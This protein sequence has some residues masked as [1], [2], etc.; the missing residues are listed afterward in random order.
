MQTN[1]KWEISAMIKLRP[2]APLVGISFVLCQSVVAATL[3]GTVQSDEHAVR[4]A[5]VTLSSA[6][7]MVSETVYSD[8]AGRYQLAT[9]LSG[10]LT[11]RARAPLKADDARSIDVPAG[12]AKINQSLVLRRLMTPQAISDSL[13][14]SAHFARIK[15]PTLI[16]RE[17]FQT[18]CLSCHEIGN[19]FTR[20]AH[21]PE[22]WTA[23]LKI[24]TVYCGYTSQV[25]VADYAAAMQHAFD[26]TPT[27][28]HEDVVVDQ[29][30]LGARITEWK[31]R[32]ALVA[33]DTEFNPNDGKFYTTDEASDRIFVTDP[34]SNITTTIPLPD[35]GTPVGG[36]FAERNLPVPFNFNVRHG[37]HSLQLAADGLFYMTGA[38]GG[39]I[40][41]FDPK[42]G[43]YKAYRIGGTALY[44]HTLRF[45]SKG[46]IWF[47]L[48][49]SNQVGRF[50][51]RTGDI[52]IIE[53]PTNMARVD[54]RTTAPY[55]IDISPLDGSIWYSKLWANKIGRVDPT[56]LEVREFEPPVIG[57][58]RLRFDA[59]GALWIPGFGDGKVAKLD[60]RTM[61]YQVHRLPTLADDEV[62]APYALAVD[63]HTQD[64]WV[65]ALMSDRMF[66]FVQKTGRFVA[67][68][69]PTRG[70]YFRDIVFPG[71]GRVC[72]SSNPMPPL[73]EV[74]EGGMDSLVCLQP[75][76]A[77]RRR[78]H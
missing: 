40:G 37:V 52:K 26:G 47:T 75:T 27:S 60:T 57:P 41:V 49:M 24:M 14:A 76:A 77:E 73:P 33:H 48:H 18:D 5:L 38:I 34:K 21:T 22:E 68:P 51:P 11:L 35:G 53:L 20:K 50:D 17:Q 16:A 39:E 29:E 61:K 69:L 62:E 46:I 8:D 58:R 71:D 74:I 25:H 67:Y 31:L 72:A 59:S 36:R 3:V 19:P 1:E 23:I 6:D 65:S 70:T 42:R 45:D 78:Q 15:F 43:T 2:I 13:P 7:G 32:G 30:A 4:G 56:T 12:D 28:A 10:K 9:Q 55:G 44:P 54:E 64:V 63:P 66:Q